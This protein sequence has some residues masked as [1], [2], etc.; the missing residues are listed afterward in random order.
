MLREKAIPMIQRCG[1]VL[2]SAALVL[3]VPVGSCFAAGTGDDPTPTEDV[4]T[5]AQAAT[6]ARLEAQS[7]AVTPAGTIEPLVIDAPY[8]YLSTPS[9]KQETNYWCGPATVQVIDDYLGN[10]TS[11]YAYSVFMS[12]TQ[13]GTDFSKVDDALQ[14]YTGSSYYYYGNLTESAFNAKVQDTIL[15]HSRPLAADVNIVGSQW[16]LY[17]YDHSG[18]IIPLEAFDW[19]YSQIRIN[20]VYNEADYYVNGGSTYGHKTYPQSVI[21]DG[22]N[23]HFRRAVVAAP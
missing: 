16:P 1:A 3:A 19:R 8:K 17:N 23:R 2:L 20:D 12:T 14:F 5:A 6:K 10:C 9:H 11:Q 15:N 21:W 18:H 7:S 13:S 4:L 22:V